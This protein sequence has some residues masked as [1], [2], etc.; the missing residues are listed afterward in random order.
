MVEAMAL[1]LGFLDLGFRAS[2]IGIE[3]REDVLVGE[4]GVWGVEPLLDL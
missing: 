2:L 4:F 1:C 3:E